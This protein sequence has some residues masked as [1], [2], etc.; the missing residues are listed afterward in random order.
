LVFIKQLLPQ[1]LTVTYNTFVQH[2]R[3]SALGYRPKLCPSMD[4][5]ALT[6]LPLP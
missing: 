5:W 1:G 2:K 6:S 4:G 3:M